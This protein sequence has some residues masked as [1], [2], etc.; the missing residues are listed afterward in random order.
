M[1]QRPPP[2]VMPPSI[3]QQILAALER[4][5]EL[6]KNPPTVKPDDK[7]VRSKRA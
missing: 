3:H 2:V 7:Q 4:I 6:L 1:T 5:E